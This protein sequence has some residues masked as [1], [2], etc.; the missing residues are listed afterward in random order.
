MKYV[1]YAICIII[2]TGLQAAL[3]AEF[4]I[5]HVVPNLL[6]LFTV[7]MAAKSE[8]YEFVFV[9]LIA[10]F[11]SDTIIG[12]PI[13]SFMLGY[14]LLALIV[15]ALFNWLITLTFDWKYVPLVALAG[16]ALL[17]L[18]LA[19]FAGI[20]QRIASQAIPVDF[21][22]ALSRMLPILVVTA[23]AMY[24]VYWLTDGL[25]LF[26]DRIEMRKKGIGL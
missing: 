21:T 19:V 20:A 3:F 14:T 24:P 16:A 12:L 7:F 11:F 13:G 4:P 10:G 23:I 22:I 26:L 2:F 1:V 25:V 17:Q 8:G 9:A 18:W 5:W 6:L 15:N